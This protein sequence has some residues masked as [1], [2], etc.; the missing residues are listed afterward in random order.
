[1]SEAQCDLTWMNMLMGGRGGG[2]KKEK[3]R[4]RNISEAGELGSRVGQSFS[5]APRLANAHGT[6][7]VGNNT[8][9]EMVNAF[10]FQIFDHLSPQKTKGHLNQLAIC[11][12]S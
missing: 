7:L 3:R 5:L 1:M 11:L 12:W 8:T 4:R 10:Y 6:R 2:R 9:H